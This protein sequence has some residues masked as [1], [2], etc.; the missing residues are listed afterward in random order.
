MSEVKYTKQIILT[1]TECGSK[2]FDCIGHGGYKTKEPG[3]YQ[4]LLGYQCKKCK[5]VTTA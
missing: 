5:H 1:C 4:I 3:H 2:D